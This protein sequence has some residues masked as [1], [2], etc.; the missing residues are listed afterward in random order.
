MHLIGE[1]AVITVLAASI[2]H[3]S[4][5]PICWTDNSSSL[6]IEPSWQAEAVLETEAMSS[7]PPFTT[8]HRGNLRSSRA[9]VQVIIRRTAM[10]RQLPILTAGGSA[11]HLRC[12]IGSRTAAEPLAERADSNANYDT[13]ARDDF[14]RDEDR[15][16]GC[17]GRAH[18]QNG[19]SNSHRFQENGCRNGQPRRPKSVPR[20]A[21]GP[22]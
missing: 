18:R 7:T 10:M 1:P 19:W 14:A 2:A 21:I 22:C 13:V 11:S 17:D 9:F 20:R 16:P 15:R 6:Q 8:G 5:E 4:P 12:R 3:S